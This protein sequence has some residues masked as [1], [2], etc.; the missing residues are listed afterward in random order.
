LRGR[1]AEGIEIGQGGGLRHRRLS[2]ID[3]EN[4]AQPMQSA[5]GSV[6]VSYNGEIYNF[7]EL[8][9]QLERLG[10]AFS[11]RSDTEVLLAAYQQW[12]DA[13]VDHLLGMFAFA[14]YDVPRRRLLLARD[15][16]GV[17]PL[18]YVV[19]ETKALAFGSEPKA[20]LS[21]PGVSRELDPLAL[22]AYLDVYYVPPP[23]SMFRGIR[24]LPPGHTLTWQDG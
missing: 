9:A 24:Q 18:Y 17:K 5:N 12:G 21:V 11:T 13:C 23:L 3:L 10:H 19:L 8:R 1:D 4:G 15:R 6:W 7:R 22:D 16:V 2:I 20:L 14:I